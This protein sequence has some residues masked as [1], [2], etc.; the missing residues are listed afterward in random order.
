M[1]SK[2]FQLKIITKEELIKK[3]LNSEGELGE[4]LRTYID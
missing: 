1:L 3:T 4:E 2:E